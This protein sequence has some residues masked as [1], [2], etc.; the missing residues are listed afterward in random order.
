MVCKTARDILKE[1]MRFSDEFRERF[2]AGFNA[3]N[4]G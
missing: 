4:D 3:E 1:G 2:K